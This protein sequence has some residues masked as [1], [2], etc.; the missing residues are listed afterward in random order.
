MSFT[1]TLLRADQMLDSSEPQEP[2]PRRGAPGQ[3]RRRTRRVH[4]L[5]LPMDI[6]IGDH[7]LTRRV[8]G[9]W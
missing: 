4:G 7:S 8:S 5:V 3:S 6:Q 9:R 2:K 1:E